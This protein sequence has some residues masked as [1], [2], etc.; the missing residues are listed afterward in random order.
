MG[1]VEIGPSPTSFAVPADLKLDVSDITGLSIDVI[2]YDDSQRLW[3]VE[4]V[5]LTGDSFVT[6]STTAT[7][8]FA[9]VVADIV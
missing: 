3:V 4:Q 7:G 9:F 8:A 1:S 6:A 5:G 2:R